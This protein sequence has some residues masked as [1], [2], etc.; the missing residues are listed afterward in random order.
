MSFNK[1]SQNPGT[2]EIL[3]LGDNFD[4]LCSGRSY[5]V[6]KFEGRA[7][8]RL[9]YD[10][11]GDNLTIPNQ[12]VT[13]TSLM[14]GSANN[15]CLGWDF[16]EII[17]TRVGNAI[18]CSFI[19]EGHNGANDSSASGIAG[20]KI[21]LPVMTSSGLNT[22]TRTYGSGIAYDGNLYSGAE[23]KNPD[24]SFMSS[25]NSLYAIVSVNNNK[26]SN[27]VVRGNFS[28]YLYY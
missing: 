14:N 6:G 9:Q 24:G 16:C 27:G 7:A 11:K 19:I 25:E 22:E 5:F 21:P 26:G 28:Y 17:W 20:V 4:V 13:A 10:N 3:Q 23:V 12:Y 18:N 8:Q 15:T 2:W 1:L